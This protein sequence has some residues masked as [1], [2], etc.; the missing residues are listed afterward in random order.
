MIQF[1]FHVTYCVL[2]GQLYMWRMFFERLFLIF[3]F[4]SDNLF[5]AF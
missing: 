1:Q 2:K 5:Y 3:V 4:E